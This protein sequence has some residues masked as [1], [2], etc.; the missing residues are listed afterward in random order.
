MHWL[1]RSATALPA[2]LLVGLWLAAEGAS[3]APIAT[4]GSQL[5]AQDWDKH[6]VQR[7]GTWL[8]E[9]YS[10]A[11]SWS[12]NLPLPTDHSHPPPQAILFALQGICT[13]LERA[14]VA[15]EHY[16][17]RALTRTPPAVVDTY[18]DAADAHDFHFA[19]VDCAANGDL[20]HAHD[21]KYYPSILLYTD[22]GEHVVEYE[23]RR[24]LS[25]LGKF[26]EE[27]YPVNAERLEGDRVKAVKAGQTH[28]DK[29][30]SA[31]E[32]MTDE[33]VGMG[34]VNQKV[35]GVW[36]K[37]RL[38]KVVADDSA[39]EDG[40]VAKPVLHIVDEPPSTSSSASASTETA[41]EDSSDV[42]AETDLRSP[43]RD[44]FAATATATTPMV[45]LTSQTPPATA[46]STAKFT[47]P[48]F[49]AQQ[50]PS[51]AEK[52]RANSEE[53]EQEQVAWPVL[54]GTVLELENEVGMALIKGKDDVPPSFVKYFAPWCSHCKAMAPGTSLC[55]PPLSL[56]GE[57]VHAG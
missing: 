36:G 8:V 9:H 35:A 26:V 51:P 56:S 53:E 3:A 29:E 25:Q 46:D 7:G 30:W 40:K 55:C 45:V 38:P 6:V 2:A 43:S 33:Q 41:D 17:A 42:D 14:Y 24:T 31:K 10:Y 50:P 19:Q 48:A 44:E 52:K 16:H 1:A 23:E 49:V 54:D 34:T 37:A 57:T 15:W 39:E 4:A 27:H 28:E 22:N 20:C 12:P 21:V 5:T 11:P 47:P 13:D 18:R 32:Q